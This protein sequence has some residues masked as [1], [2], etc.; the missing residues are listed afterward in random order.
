M[1]LLSAIPAAA[2]AWARFAAEAPEATKVPTLSEGVIMIGI[3]AQGLLAHF[4]GRRG[5]RNDATMVTSV[6]SAVRASVQQVVDQHEVEDVKRFNEISRKLDEIGLTVETV[7]S[8]KGLRGDVEK[9]ANDVIGLLD[10]EREA[11]QHQVY[12]RRRS[13]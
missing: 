4:K 10:R 7:D 8:D 3:A 9:I 6:T 1:T 2:A 5:K 12:D 13:S 11:L